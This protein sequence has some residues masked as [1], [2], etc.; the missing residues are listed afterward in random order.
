MRWLLAPD[1]SGL[2]NV[3][4]FLVNSFDEP[5][6]ALTI[7]IA[8]GTITAY[9]AKPDLATPNPG[10]PQWIRTEHGWAH[11]LTPE[12][13]PLSTSAHHHVIAGITAHRVNGT[14]TSEILILNLAAIDELA[15]E[16]DNPTPI[17]RAWT[18]QLLERTPAA[19]IEVLREDLAVPGHPRL[20]DAT[21]DQLP[22]TPDPRATIVVADNARDLLATDGPSYF[23]KILTKPLGEPENLLMCDG[24]LA[25][26]YLTGGIFFPI[27]RRIE[28][29]E[30]RWHTF[31][32]A[33]TP[34]TA[35]WGTDSPT[36]PPAP[37]AH[38]PEKSETPPWVSNDP[39]AVPTPSTADTGITPAAAA[40]TNELE[41]D[42]SAAPTEA[43]ETPVHDDGPPW[44]TDEPTP[45]INPAVAPT[46][47]TPSTTPSTGHDIAAEADQEL[48]D[49]TLLEDGLD[50]DELP[51]ITTAPPTSHTTDLTG[52]PITEYKRPGLYVLGPVLVAG[53][54]TKDE[55]IESSALSRQGVRKPVKGIVIVAS[56]AGISRSEWDKMM[57]LTNSAA[58]RTARAEI[59]KIT[60]SQTI[61]LEET[62]SELYILEDGFY[63]DWK[64]LDHLVGINPATASDA[65]L[66]TAASLIRGR[67]FE[68]INPTDYEP[69]E[70][71]WP[72]LR[73]LRDRLTDLAANVLLELG[74][75]QADTN[76]D[77][78]YR[79]AR[80]A[81][82]INP[83]RE[84]LWE[85]AVR[86]APAAERRTLFVY[87][88]EAIPR[89]ES[90]LL[91]AFVSAAA[92]TR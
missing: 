40:D 1:G 5:I 41:P 15:L 54:T 16:A 44:R 86:T 91:R 31:T 7:S 49:A 75:R 77:L 38:E 67:P 48:D 92:A 33:Y 26:I 85:L 45:T 84:D 22:L 53:K 59:R 52:A 37:A 62:G 80:R 2:V 27:W 81:T 89:Q 36:A 65:D 76:P 63:C 25:S 42:I 4:Q 17:L 10:Y 11:P 12:Q 88:V 74:N 46:I 13:F 56:H 60:G 79:T 14:I 55:L 6:A 83:A 18:S 32:A 90:K 64:D 69:P 39:P 20:N 72:N 57:G 82:D 66:A 50:N 78:A 58:S 28:L 51:A 21:L 8:D 87:L 30:T 19:H 9:P 3:A 61:V 24:D 35:L 68:D 71:N 29:D 47:P 43:G 73:L 70:Y 34:T 23:T